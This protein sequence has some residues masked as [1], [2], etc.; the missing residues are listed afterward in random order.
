MLHLIMFI[1]KFKFSIQILKYGD[2]LHLVTFTRTLKINVM[3]R[4]EFIVD[5]N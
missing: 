2:L 3:K 1:L 5:I 4:R